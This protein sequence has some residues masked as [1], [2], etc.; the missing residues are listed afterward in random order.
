MSTTRESGHV[1]DD[2]G[3]TRSVGRQ[4]N[5]RQSPSGWRGMC[6]VL[7][8]DGVIGAVIDR[9]ADFEERQ[10]QVSKADCDALDRRYRVD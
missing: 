2:H 1:G 7:N 5:A 8:K 3:W 4:A 10:R 9:L 6:T